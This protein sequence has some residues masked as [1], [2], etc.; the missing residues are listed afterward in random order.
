MNILVK[1]AN[2]LVKNLII[3]GRILNFLVRKMGFLVKKMKVLVRKLNILVKKQPRST[4][5]LFAFQAK[6]I[7]LL[8]TDFSLRF[9]TFE[10]TILV[11]F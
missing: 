9:A 3:L 2:N 5:G 8:L 10:M 6:A 11:R 7:V 4:A 1:N